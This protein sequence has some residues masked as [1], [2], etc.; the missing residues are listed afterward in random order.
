MVYDARRPAWHPTAAFAQVQHTEHTQQW[1]LAQHP[2]I[3][4]YAPPP[5]A[6]YYYAAAPIVPS[7]QHVA[8]SQMHMPSHHHHA[9]HA[10]PAPLQQE[11]KPSSALS[12]QNRLP[13]IVAS[14]PSTVERVEQRP[15]SEFDVTAHE[16]MESPQATPDINRIA[17]QQHQQQ[18]DQLHLEP[19]Q[20][21]L[22]QQVLHQQGRHQHSQPPQKPQQDV[23]QSLPQQHQQ[24]AVP[25][26]S[27]LPPML[28]EPPS[29]TSALSAVAYAAAAAAPLPTKKSD[30]SV[31]TLIDAA[32]L[33]ALADIALNTPMIMPT[34]P[35]MPSPKELSFLE[36]PVATALVTA[37]PSP[38]D[39]LLRAVET[40]ASAHQHEQKQLKWAQR[41]QQQRQGHQEQREQHTQDEQNNQ[42]NQQQYEQG[43]Q[44]YE[45]EQVREQE[46]WEQVEQHRQDE[47]QRTEQK[48]QRAAKQQQNRQQRQLLQKQQREQQR[49]HRLTSTEDRLQLPS[50]AVFLPPSLSTAP[51]PLSPSP[52]PTSG[53][54]Q[55]ASL[56]PTSSASVLA[57]RSK[58]SADEDSEPSCS[59]EQGS[60]ETRCPCGSTAD[61]ANMIAC[62]ECN[63]WQHNKC[64]G[65]RRR[66]DIPEKYYCHICRP[67]EMRPNCIAH[68]RYKERMAGREKNKDF[69]PALSAVKPLELRRLFSADLK[70]CRDDRSAVSFDDMFRRY[71]ALYRSQFGKDRQSVIEGLVV[72]T[73]FSRTDV[74]DRLEQ[75][76][77]KMR[78]SGALRGADFGGDATLP[79]DRKHSGMETVVDTVAARVPSFGSSGV[80]PH[81]FQADDAPISIC[82]VDDDSDNEASHSLPTRRISSGTSGY[83]DGEDLIRLGSRRSAKTG[84]KRP[85]PASLAFIGE[86]RAS[87]ADARGTVVSLATGGAAAVSDGFPSSN[88]PV[89]DSAGLDAMKE[90]I[91][92]GRSLS[93]E[94]RKLFQ[95]MQ[96]FKRMEEQQEAR[97]K[98]KPR[99]AMA[100]DID[101]ADQLDSTRVGGAGHLDS[102]G[103]LVETGEGD[104]AGSP[105]MDVVAA[106]SQAAL[107]AAEPVVTR[108]ERECVQRRERPEL[109]ERDR[110]RIERQRDAGGDSNRD[111]E[112]GEVASGGK[113]EKE[114]ERSTKVEGI[115]VSVSNRERHRRRVELRSAAATD[116]SKGDVNGKHTIFDVD[117]APK[118]SSERPPL[119]PA[120]VF[121]I[122]VPGPSVLGSDLIPASRRSAI[123][124]QARLDEAAVRVATADRYA[125]KKQ[126]KEEALV[127]MNA[128][129]GFMN[130]WN[131]CLPA[132][133]AWLNSQENHDEP[134]DIDAV[135]D[136]DKDDSSIM[137]VDSKE[138]TSVPEAKQEPLSVSMVVVSQRE[139]LPDQGKQIES[140]RLIGVPIAEKAPVA[141]A[142]SATSSARVTLPVTLDLE[143]IIRHTIVRAR[144]GPRAECVK[145]RAA[146][147][148]GDEKANAA[149]VTSAPA[150]GPPPSSPLSLPV[151]RSPM[152]GLRSAPLVVLN[153]PA[154]TGS[155]Y[156]QDGSAKG[157]FASC[158][159][160]PG[161]FSVAG[162]TA[163]SAPLP[164]RVRS[165][166]VEINRKST[167]S[168]VLRAPSPLLK[169]RLVAAAAKS[170]V[171]RIAPASSVTS[172]PLTSTAE[173]IGQVVVSLPAAARAVAATMTGSPTATEK[174][175]VAPAT[176]VGFASNAVVTG[177]ESAVRASPLS[178]DRVPRKIPTS[179]AVSGLGQQTD[180]RIP[181]LFAPRSSVPCAALSPS[182]S[183]SPVASPRLQLSTAASPN[184]SRFPRTNSR[185][186]TPGTG[187]LKPGVDIASSSVLKR[188]G[189]ASAIVNNSKGPIL[190]RQATSSPKP[191]TTYGTSITPQAS[192]VGGPHWRNKSSSYRFG[193]SVP[194]P[195]GSSSTP[196]SGS[197]GNSSASAGTMHENKRHCGM[198]G[199]SL[200]GVSGVC[201]P[202]TN[203]NMRR[204]FPP[205]SG[206]GFATGSGGK[207]QTP[208]GG[209]VVTARQPISGNV[210]EV[211][212]TAC[213][214]NGPAGVVS[215]GGGNASAATA[216]WSSF[217][218]RNG[219]SQTQ[220]GEQPDGGGGNGNRRRGESNLY[221]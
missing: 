81:G 69:D 182:P 148:F 164:F 72:V 177:K 218:Q 137:D 162:G 167:S 163:M 216:A 26:T 102:Q 53:A 151:A 105:A 41:D 45:L 99:T 140:S 67:E 179:T 109:R 100:G 178:S 22:Q 130:K 113:K 24:R 141:A 200:G 94:D 211:G 28:T 42:H 176:Q 84:S 203:G 217:R 145:K 32:P 184:G 215:G 173:P 115:L 122:H 152:L 197:G 172:V 124:N 64:M 60:E 62:D 20:Q 209:N 170:P 181:R 153:T 201:K 169:K 155:N 108:V 54:L 49:E 168:P 55:V 87:T 202:S 146:M 138:D 143:D 7:Q 129:R 82:H 156:L 219:W 142:D 66:G 90:S 83:G 158:N 185:L 88:M 93:R 78:T 191:A 92:N 210:H 38:H 47:A 31:P 180:D 213:G 123:E 154:A 199:G 65:I 73:D 63:T 214:D 77:R 13:A 97:G 198:S 91:A 86:D 189:S 30:S 120:L 50:R 186:S 205:P 188:I 59:D 98:K 147:L 40:L 101:K 51:P 11:R 136:K 133:K 1:H 43:M 34:A 36:S 212:L 89:R 85:R 117:A 131:G 3:Y 144:S 192:A 107:N 149:L 80:R 159:A 112:Q 183:G 56:S 114:K 71:A 74:Q 10:A 128:M 79:H 5:P 125:L 4:G 118:A 221:N 75:M 57:V 15:A 39:N 46:Q 17:K 25:T 19:E 95:I 6:G 187:N 190:P 48:R 27:L 21:Q 116:G 207:W 204:S 110:A 68:P 220:G 76:L 132:K 194:G 106:S 160:S 9:Y 174:P 33:A 8:P 119:D 135:Q 29:S 206:P 52:P 161:A 104:E 2:I 196:S 139:S 175:S 171:P 134:T 44:F 16:R 103:S 58:E 70:A 121:R 12:D 166:Q 157:G 195:K 193:S 14:L 61:S 35:A 111:P 37:V 126:W 23:E 96:M 208:G 18:R 150:T 165:S 127:Q